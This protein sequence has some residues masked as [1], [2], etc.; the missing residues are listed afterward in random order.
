MLPEAGVERRRLA[1]FMP[2]ENELACLAAMKEALVTIPSGDCVLLSS[3]D[4]QRL[5]FV[6]PQNVNA[7]RLAAI[8]GS[9]CG[10]GE[11]L[12]RE[13]EQQGFRDVIIQTDTGVAVVQRIPH[14][15]NRLVLMAAAGSLANMGIVSS[16][17]RYC[18]GAIAELCF[19][20]RAE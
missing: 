6:A 4:G 10:L 5:A 12:G 17:T 8:V 3:T 7:S 18:A 13:L 19:P 1:K 11:T 2:L 9:L 15:S 16:H 14:A 20:A